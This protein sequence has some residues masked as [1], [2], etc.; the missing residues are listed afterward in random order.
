MIREAR[1]AWRIILS[2]KTG[3]VMLKMMS[4]L[5]GRPVDN[6]EMATLSKTQDGQEKAAL[7]KAQDNLKALQ[8]KVAYWSV[9][10]GKEDAQFRD[11]M[12]SGIENG[13]GP[14]LVGPSGD[15]EIDEKG[16]ENLHDRWIDYLELSGKDEVKNEA[17]VLRQKVQSKSI[18]VRQ[19]LDEIESVKDRYKG[20]VKN[21]HLS[22][23]EDDAWEELESGK[24]WSVDGYD[25]YLVRRFPLLSAVAG[26]DPSTDKSKTEW[27]VAKEY[28]YFKDYGPPYYLF[29]KNHD[30]VMLL[31][32]GSCQ[33]K[34]VDDAPVQDKQLLETAGKFLMDV[35]NADITDVKMDFYNIPGLLEY[36][37]SIRLAANGQ[38][39]SKEEVEKAA[40][41]PNPAIRAAFAGNSRHI[42]QSRFPGLARELVNDESEKVRM[43]MAGQIHAN[44]PLGAELMM[45]LAKDQS[46]NVRRTVAEMVFK[47]TPAE[48]V[49]VLANDPDISVRC[50]L[51]A[52]SATDDGIRRKLADTDSERLRLDIARGTASGDILEKLAEDT[53]N[54][55][56]MLEICKNN[57]ATGKAL[58]TLLPKAGN[59]RM[60]EYIESMLKY[61]GRK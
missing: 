36:A 47:N 54:A 34:D 6:Q 26:I 59:R 25:V 49:D 48:I 35:L 44:D 46:V 2:Y 61:H 17:K 55:Y 45:Q 18:G 52:N 7:T 40:R 13:D 20:L 19:F 12:W 39:T 37:K 4:E 31:H 32:I 3:K 10:Q 9:F 60:K 16:C 11:L 24:K 57:C 14:V 38:F 1:I 27:C 15:P 28:S 21:N 29:A 56:V 5:I 42:L 43:A 30:P 41:D 22:S 8:D 51:A 53:S 33:L 23:G 58:Q 50:A